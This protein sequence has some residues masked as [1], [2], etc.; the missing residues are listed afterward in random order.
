MNLSPPPK[1]K[2]VAKQRRIWGMED[3]KI[4]SMSPAFLERV[5][6]RL[7]WAM[8]TQARW[9]IPMVAFCDLNHCIVLKDDARIC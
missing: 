5:Q 8:E 1:K 4:H 7:I 6:S 2:S 9:N 3:G